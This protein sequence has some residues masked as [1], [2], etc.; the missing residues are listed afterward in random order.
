MADRRK[1]RPERPGRDKVPDFI[2]TVMSS[3]TIKIYGTNSPD[4]AKTRAVN[5]VRG[6]FDGIDSDL[7]IPR[8]LVI[9]GGLSAEEVER[10][11]A[12]QTE[13]MIKRQ[14]EEIRNIKAEMMPDTESIKFQGNADA[15]LGNEEELQKEKPRPEDDPYA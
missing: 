2:V 6:L 15:D 5:R 3:C 8:V 1:L 11:M 10:V 9:P 13:G 14:Q 4:E 12:Q 7:Y